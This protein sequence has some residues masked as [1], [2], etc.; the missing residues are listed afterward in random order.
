M[1]KIREKIEECNNQNSK[2]L[3]AFITSGYPNPKSFIDL[4][5]N[6]SEAGADI[7]E[8]GL[9]FGDSL[10]DGPVIQSSYIKSLEYGINLD[11]TLKY[12]AEIKNEIDTPIIL[13]SSSNPVLN[14]GIDNFCSSAKASGI[15]GVI[16]PDVPLEEYDE[17]F[18]NDFNGLDTILLTTPTSTENRIK[19]IDKRSSGFVYCVSVVGTTGVRNKFDDYVLSNLE[20]TYQTVSLNKMQIGFGI[21]SPEN[22]KQF[23][24]YCDGFIV[25]SAIIKSLEKDDS[26]YSNTL[27]LIRELKAACNI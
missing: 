22:I 3:T 27:N 19:E 7:I 18:T 20:R 13:M 6:V 16:I 25:G 17:F 5:V 23:S 1:S 4:I 8:I 21:S 12:I 2:S 24:N 11:R 10:A 9:P 15:D 26:D 14:F